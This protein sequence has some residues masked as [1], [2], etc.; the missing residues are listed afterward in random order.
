M[1]LAASDSALFLSRP[2]IDWRK[3]D[4]ALFT[5]ITIVMSA[6]DPHV[7]LQIPSAGFR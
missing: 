2:S 1:G 4:A 6:Y 5:T 7:A 3:L